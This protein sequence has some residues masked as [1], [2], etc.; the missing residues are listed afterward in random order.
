MVRPTRLARLNVL[1]II[2]TIAAAFGPAKAGHYNRIRFAHENQHTSKT[3]APPNTHDDG[4]WQS[5][6][7]ITTTSGTSFRVGKHDL[8]SV[9]I[10]RTRA[11]TAVYGRLT[12]ELD[13][14]TRDRSPQH[15]IP[16]L[17]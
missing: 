10:A 2:L 17:I 5:A 3:H 16:L 12:D 4:I 6:R 7:Q 15:S 13:N 8:R 14:P 1:A 11:L 9:T